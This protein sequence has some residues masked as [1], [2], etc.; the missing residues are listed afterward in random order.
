MTWPCAKGVA[1]I[2]FH[3]LTTEIQLPPRLGG[4]VTIQTDGIS[5]GSPLGPSI[6][7]V[8][9][10]HIENKIFNTIKKPKLYVRYVDDIFIATQSHDEINK[11][12]QI[13]EKNSV[14]KFTTELNINKKKSL[15][16]RPHRF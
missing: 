2:H 7:K 11:L 6:S 10:S 14:L 3:A 12:K 5:I 9:I 8:Y 4:A 16:R 1:V 15:P 13:L